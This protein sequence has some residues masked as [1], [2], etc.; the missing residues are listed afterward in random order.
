METISIRKSLKWFD[1]WYKERQYDRA[2]KVA[3][4]CLTEVNQSLGDQHPLAIDCMLKIAS[5]YEKL[6]DY[7]E[8]DQWFDK[9]FAIA[10]TIY[11]PDDLEMAT[12]WQVKG[13]RYINRGNF[14]SALP[15]L[16]RSLVIQSKA[17]E[18]R[19]P[20]Y[21]TTLIM[22]A[23]VQT[24][25]GDWPKAEISA[26]QALDLAQ[27]IYSSEHSQVREADRI[28][29]LVRT[30]LGK[31]EGPA[32]AS[33]KMKAAAGR[34]QEMLANGN[35]RDAAAEVSKLLKVLESQGPQ[36]GHD[37]LPESR[38][39]MIHAVILLK[40]GASIEADREV[41]RAIGIEEQ[42]M[43]RD[44]LLSVGVY[45]QAGLLKQQLGKI[46]EADQFLNRC[47]RITIQNFGDEHQNL[48]PILQLG[49]LARLKLGHS[50]EGM[51]LLFRAARLSQHLQE[52]L[53]PVLTEEQKIAL[54]GKLQSIVFTLLVEAQ[55]RTATNPEFAAE[56]YN[57]W[58]G[59]KGGVFEAQGRIH[60]SVIESKD[61]K[62]REMARSLKE[63]RLQLARHLQNRPTGPPTFRFLD[64]LRT[65]QSKKDSLEVEIGKV[66]QAFAQGQRDQIMKTSDIQGCLQPED[67]L[68][69]FARVRPVDP[70]T[71]NFGPPRYF[72][73]VLTGKQK[74]KIELLDI[75][76]AEPI[77]KEIRQFQDEIQSSA[78]KG[79]QIRL[80]ALGGLLI[81]PLAPW[82]KGRKRIYISPDGPLNLLP[83]ELL[84]GIGSSLLLDRSSVSYLSTGRDLNRFGVQS[85]SGKGILLLANPD[86]DRQSA[87]A[88]ALSE[89]TNGTSG[90]LRGDLR[91]LSFSPLANT[92]GEADDIAGL[93]PEGEV[94]NLQGQQAS[95]EALTARPGIRILHMA[96]HG[97]FL[98]SVLSQSL[99]GSQPFDADALFGTQPQT[100]AEKI[101]R[102]ARRE[103]PLLVSGLA[104]AGANSALREGRDEGLLT[105]DKVLDL[106]LQGTD[107]VV[108]SAC[109]TGKGRI[110]DGE[111]VFGLKRGFFLAGARSMV[112]SLWK[113]PDRETRKLMVEFYRRWLAGSTKAEALAEAKQ[114]I[115]NH[116]PNPFYWG[117]FILVGDP[118]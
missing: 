66:S 57:V 17:G 47:Q 37:R 43:G 23:S 61:P 34:F 102:D 10:Q 3:K 68:V 113:V 56:S 107:L 103:N 11:K 110:R 82:I 98:D 13:A 40:S 54:H 71:M 73:F 111:G 58:L 105:A 78:L 5:G 20:R 14:R 65:L 63:A 41:D 67:T 2:I 25:L 101:L 4:K 12:Q 89:S 15:A 33:T 91:E 36:V 59:A 31:S 30:N 117:A 100:G 81:K 76:P 96:T 32:L 46:E 77:D 87:P 109:N 112:V 51:D 48:L 93:F 64:Q 95:E 70:K 108:L 49:G 7:A 22:L 39:R 99:D 42:V 84:P 79:L 21:L 27:S 44:H 24:D 85:A 97:F 115:R 1:E 8:T 62:I 74:D 118:N 29:R 38:L 92:K 94:T 106:N 35:F 52:S 6:S 28:L 80:N 104:L 9:A 88:M 69:D 60:G 53:F 116:Q 45:L 86:Y 83:F 90:Q 114:V 18:Q 55:R 72:A 16:E 50:Q 26:K 19:K 75:G